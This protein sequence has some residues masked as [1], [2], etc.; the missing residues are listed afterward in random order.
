[1]VPPSVAHRA[2]VQA[3]FAPLIARAEA[4]GWSRETS[5]LRETAEVGALMSAKFWRDF[6]LVCASVIGTRQRIVNN[7]AILDRTKAERMVRV[8]RDLPGD[9]APHAESVEAL[10]AYLSE[11]AALYTE[12][13]ALALR[14]GECGVA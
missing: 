3:A 6:T 10:V 5:V 9:I 7:L 13:V 12:A 4:S 8:I 11:S 2:A 14:F 1:M